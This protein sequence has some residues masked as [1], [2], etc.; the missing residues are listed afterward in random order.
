MLEYSTKPVGERCELRTINLPS[1]KKI[2]AKDSKTCF[3]V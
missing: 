3:K 2:I 1:L